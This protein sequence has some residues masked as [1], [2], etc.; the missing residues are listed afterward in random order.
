MPGPV[1]PPWP[2]CVARYC[3]QGTQICASCLLWASWADAF[4]VVVDGNLHFAHEVAG[5]FASDRSL[6]G[7]QHMTPAPCFLPANQLEEDPACIV[8]GPHPCRGQWV[9]EGAGRLPQGSRCARCASPRANHVLRTVPPQLTIAYA[10]SHDQAVCETLPGAT[11]RSQAR[12]VET[13]LRQI[14]RGVAPGLL[15]RRAEQLKFLLQDVQATEFWLK[16]NLAASLRG[17]GR[18]TFGAGASSQERVTGLRHGRV[19]ARDSDGRLAGGLPRGG[20]S[21][22]DMVYPSS[23]CRTRRRQESRRQTADAST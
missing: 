18:H 20:G 10:R 11:A 22:G 6:I 21:G 14:R 1:G 3:A 7:N 8:G 12:Q 16:K 9:G 4:C 19:C 17:F 2:T 5:S 13:A 23:G 15:G